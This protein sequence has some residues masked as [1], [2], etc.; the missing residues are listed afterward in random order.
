MDTPQTRPPTPPPTPAAPQA[1]RP[2][3]PRADDPGDVE[4]ASWLRLI[5]QRLA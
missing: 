3:E 1:R 2:P 4:Y 5:R